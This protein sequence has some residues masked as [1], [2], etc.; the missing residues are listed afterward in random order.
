MDVRNRFFF[1]IGKKV[2]IIQVVYYPPRAQG[3][4]VAISRSVAHVSLK[5]TTEMMIYKDPCSIREVI[6]W[7]NR[8]SREMELRE[9]DLLLR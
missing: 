2:L 9:E 6:T 3:V 5:I 8:D 1:R 7:L 4:I